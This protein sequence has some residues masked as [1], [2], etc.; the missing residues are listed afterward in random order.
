M[1]CL[2][3]S[4]KMYFIFDV[5]TKGLPKFN[6][7]SKYR[8][9]SFKHLNKYD[10]ARLQSISWI[11]ANEQGEKI[12]QEYFIIK[13]L[14]FIIDNDSHATKIHGI[15]KEIAEDKGIPWHSMYDKFYEDLSNCK[16]LVAHNIQFD[17]S[18]MLSEMYR[19]NQHYGIDALLDKNRICTMKYGK[20]ATGALKNP[21]LSELY[22]HF[23]NE[24]IE[25][26]HDAMFDTLY[27]Y[28]CLVEMLKIPEIN[29]LMNTPYEPN[30]SV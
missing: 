22:M 1:H 4:T 18:I 24:E 13:P 14:D 27:C 21:K 15:T 20:L 26:A 28:K 29:T 30:K 6:T 23:Y 12:K 7:N 2:K 11:V 3:K 10:S 17:I 19:Y 8:F 5:E 25:N 9:P 16:T